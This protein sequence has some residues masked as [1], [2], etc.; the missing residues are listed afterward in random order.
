MKKPFFARFLEHQLTEADKLRLQGGEPGGPVTDK[1]PSDS[2]ET[3]PVT[4]SA[5]LD[6]IEITYT[7]Q[8]VPSDQE[9]GII[10][11]L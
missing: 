4:N 5:I 8:K 6:V 2:D 11:H 3:H 9:E 1:V 10:P 7:T